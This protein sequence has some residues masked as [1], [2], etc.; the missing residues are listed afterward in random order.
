MKHHKPS[1]TQ[2]VKE[3]KGIFAVL[4]NFGLRYELA[5][6][7][8][9]CAIGTLRVLFFCAAFPFFNNVDEQAH[10]DIV[11]RYAKLDIP[12]GLEAYSKEAIKKIS[13]SGSW[14]FFFTP[15][16]VNDA[17][18][19]IRIKTP[20]WKFK[21]P[22]RLAYVQEVNRQFQIQ[23]NHESV[24]PPFY[25]LIGGQW[26]NFG[27]AIGLSGIQSLYWIRMM[28][29]VFYG[30]MLWFSY[31]FMKRTYPKRHYLHFGVPA[32]L[33][34]L[35]QDMYYGIE[36]DV[37]SALLFGAAFYNLIAIY[38]D[39]S[40]SHLFHAATGLFAACALLTKLTNAPILLI[41]GAVVAL[42]L[43]QS[44][45]AGELRSVIWK[46][47]TLLLFAA[48]PI[49]IWFAYNMHFS[50]SPTL[51]GQYAEAV[52]WRTKSF[53]E[54]WDHPVFT[55][56]GFGAFLQATLASLW[57]GEY[58]WQQKPMASLGMDKF[59]AVSSS[60]FVLTFL[61]SIWSYRKKR[62]KMVMFAD[63]LSAVAFLASIGML[64]VMSMRYDFGNWF[65]PSREFPFF[66]AGRL[67][68]GALVPFI[69]M[70]LMGL[71]SVLG[72]FKL[73]RYRGIALAL[74]IVI[75]TTSEALMSRGVFA[76]AFNLF[77][78]L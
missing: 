9:L 21:H 68:S 41:L 22:E 64:I 1:I 17:E 53:W 61:V 13:T 57:R 69:A 71:G 39:K 56:G 3:P 20:A 45:R 40:R 25:Y 59:Y 62:E 70:Y 38:K 32:L 12:H 77:H 35:P 55:A 16:M 10:F 47:G 15:Q 74:I 73:K 43:Y 52:G 51:T 48:L 18:K 28:N 23:A 11:C 49:V 34:F 67:I 19:E 65:A 4:F 54:M 26:Y 58:I 63:I 66:A 24:Q 30:L 50:G 5:I 14:E 33:A 42:K 46:Q 36:S 27:K 75:V 44:L 37:P 31:V 6:V 8:M 2:V 60:L 7:L 76:S 72:V 78:N 29:V